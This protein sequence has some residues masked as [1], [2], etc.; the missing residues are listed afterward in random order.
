MEA[1]DTTTASVRSRQE[2]PSNKGQ[3]HIRL[4]IVRR[5]RHGLPLNGLWKH[6]NMA[7]TRLN[8]LHSSFSLEKRHKLLLTSSKPYISQ[9]IFKE[10]CLKIMKLHTFLQTCT[11]PQS[12]HQLHVAT[13]HL[14]CGSSKLTWDISVDNTLDFEDSTKNFFE[15]TKYFINFLH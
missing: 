4:L 13:E 15:N 2:R 9:I 6:V 14:K 7:L 5:W 8:Y 1:E 11:V 10:D 3:V 12:S